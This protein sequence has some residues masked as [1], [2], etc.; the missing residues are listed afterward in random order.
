MAANGYWL[1]SQ[2]TVLISIGGITM[3]HYIAL[4]SLKLKKKWLNWI[5]VLNQLAI[6]ILNW[7]ELN[8][9]WSNYP[10]KNAKDIP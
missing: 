5:T 3:L 4:S 9:G 6:S 7:F 1:V 10:V 8:L 2:I